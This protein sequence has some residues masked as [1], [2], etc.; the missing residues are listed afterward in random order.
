ME[1]PKNYTEG[2]WKLFRARIADWQEGYI[3]R[4]NEEY[5]A[6]LSREGSAAEN[7]WEVERRIRSDKR[8]AGVAVEMRRSVLVQNMD[9]LL[10]EGAITFDDLDGFSEELVESLRWMAEFRTK[11]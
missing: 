4:L 7:F 2:D 11:L 5:I 3:A 9:R 10:A 6:I 1:Q 8:D